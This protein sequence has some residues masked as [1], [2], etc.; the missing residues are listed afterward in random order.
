MYI[1]D[2]EALDKLA[3]NKHQTSYFDGSLSLEEMY[4]ML[5]FRSGFEVAE[6][7]VILASLVLAGA[8]F[9]R[10]PEE[11]FYFDM[12]KYIYER[13]G[14]EEP[15]VTVYIKDPE[16]TC[17][18]IPDEDNHGF[19]GLWVPMSKALDFVNIFNA[20]NKQVEGKYAY[21]W[22]QIEKNDYD[23][24]LSFERRKINMMCEMSYV[25]GYD[26][27]HDTFNNS[28][29]FNCFMKKVEEWSEEYLKEMEEE[30]VVI[31]VDDF[32]GGK[33]IEMGWK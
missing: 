5:R 29:S 9:I 33:Y 26:F 16:Y 25:F 4:E 28:A 12:N 13:V 20:A 24:E 21:I 32:L 11:R 3:E 15:Y 7:N 8:K 14:W 2:R 30:E 10:E 18:I 23:D 1:T 6:T 17:E 31:S 27:F 22:K 19:N